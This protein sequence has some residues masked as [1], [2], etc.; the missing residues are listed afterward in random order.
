MVEVVGGGTGVISIWSSSYNPSASQTAFGLRSV[1][2]MP[3]CAETRS[4]TSADLDFP[5]FEKLRS[6]F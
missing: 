2:T 5:V 6:K 3:Y 4:K 1:Q